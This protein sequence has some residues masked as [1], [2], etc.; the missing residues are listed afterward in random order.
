MLQRN[1]QSWYRRPQ[2][3]PPRWLFA[4]C[5]VLLAIMFVFGPAL[6]RIGALRF[7]SVMIMISLAQIAGKRAQDR[8]WSWLWGYL[9]VIPW[10]CADLIW[11]TE[12]IRG[13]LLGHEYRI[14]RFSGRQE[15]KAAYGWMTT[16]DNHGWLVANWNSEAARASHDKANDVSPVTLNPTSVAGLSRVIASCYLVYGYDYMTT[17]LTMSAAAG[18]DFGDLV[19]DPDVNSIT[20]SFFNAFD[21][22]MGEKRLFV[23]ELHVTRSPAGKVVR[24]DANP[25]IDIGPNPFLD[26]TQWKISAE[27][28]LHRISTVSRR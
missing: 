9:I 15:F 27:M 2:A 8:G 19:A 5:G 28:P 23:R 3:P 13:E 10:M 12:Y 21:K 24:L 4:Q 6:D 7:F 17:R 18:S 14:N 20:V 22:P 25:M 11:P 1:N 16:T 26:I